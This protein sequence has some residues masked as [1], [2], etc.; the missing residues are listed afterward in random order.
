MLLG[1]LANV[2]AIAIGTLAGFTLKQRFSDRIQSIAMQGLALVTVL[3]GTMM[4]IT[5]QNVLVVLVSTVTG[6]VLGEL[7]RIEERLDRLGAKVE[8]R[9]S[10]ERGTF[11]KAFVTSTLLYC[12]G[13]LAILGALQDGL[14]GDY[15]ILLT[16]SG[17]DGIASVAFASTLG[18]GVLFST[19]P[20]A[21]YQ[22]GITIGASLLEPYLT[23]SIINEMTATGGLLILGIALNLLQVTKIKVGNLL[24]AILVAAILSAFIV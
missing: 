8:A 22:G 10:K 19:L 1:T 18:I 4:M 15:S 7:L 9:F 20:V 21:A 11:A 24:P 3:I 13:P 5:T 2:A 17:L 6:G 23:S 12:V 14:R 16:K